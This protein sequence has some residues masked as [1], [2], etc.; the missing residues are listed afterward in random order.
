[1]NSVVQYF[2]LCK[3]TEAR[4]YN[5]PISKFL[6][7]LLKMTGLLVPIYQMGKQICKMKRCYLRILMKVTSDANG[8]GFPD[9]VSILISIAFPFKELK[10]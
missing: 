5:I 10:K 3:L 1:M 9:R 7:T 8:Y 6:G 4:R 2:L